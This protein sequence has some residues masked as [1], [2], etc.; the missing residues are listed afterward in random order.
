M[1]YNSNIKIF[2]ELYLEVLDFLK[3][4]H[5][6]SLEQIDLKTKDNKLAIYYIQGGCI[7]HAYLAIAQ[8]MSGD[9]GAPMVHK[10]I[11][12]ESKMVSLF[13][14][15]LQSNHRYIKNFF[16]GGIIIFPGNILKG[17]HFKDER[18]YIIEKTGWDIETFDRYLK[19]MKFL[20]S[21]FSKSLHPQINTLAFNSDKETGEFEYELSSSSDLFIN[22]FDFG[23]YVLI[24][25]IDTFV[26]N[27]DILPISKANLT[28]LLDY[29]K[30]VSATGKEIFDNLKDSVLNKKI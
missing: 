18:E 2:D 20:N 13:L 27:I 9:R 7:T 29:K 5:F 24:P 26:L 21:E 23:V 14:S 4:L 1:L 10:R 3:D 12:D 22:N 17:N 16:N 28:S 11:I 15:A 8:W 30:R 19:T 25:V 6:Q